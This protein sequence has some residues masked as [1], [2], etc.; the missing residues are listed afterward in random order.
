MMIAGH[1]RSLGCTLVTCVVSIIII[2]ADEINALFCDLSLFFISAYLLYL[3]TRKKF[4]KKMR[5]QA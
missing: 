2:S 4:R 1:A 5:E 3:N